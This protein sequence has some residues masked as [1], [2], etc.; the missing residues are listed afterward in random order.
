MWRSDK[1]SIGR[2]ELISAAEVAAWAYCPESWRLQYG[3]GLE[4]ENHSALRAGT[5][6]HARKAFAERLAGT[7]IMLGWILAALAAAGLLLLV[8]G[9]S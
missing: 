6:H 4:P 8:W 9:R 5:R 2:R 3:L 1:P 7:A